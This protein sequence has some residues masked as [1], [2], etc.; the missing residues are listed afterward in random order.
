MHIKCVPIL[1]VLKEIFWKTKSIGDTDER[2]DLLVH[3][4]VGCVT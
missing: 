1:R 2:K 4:I 3:V